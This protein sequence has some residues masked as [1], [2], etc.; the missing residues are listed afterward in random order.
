M[1]T[2]KIKLAYIVSS[3]VK[4]GPV[5]VILDI[6]TNI[7][8]NKFEVFIITLA[9]EKKNSLEFEFQK[10]P[11]HIIKFDSANKFNF[12]YH[13]LKLSRFIKKNNIEIIHS[14]CFRSLIYCHL[15]KKEAK[16]IHTIHNN[17]TLQAVSLYGKILGCTIS[18]ITKILIKSNNCSIACSKSV[19][20]DL[21]EKDNIAVS[22]IANGVSIPLHQKFRK[23]DEI[24][25]TL[26]LEDGVVYFLSIGRFSPEKNFQFLVKS[27]IDADLENSKLIILG[28]GK[29]YEKIKII[30]NQNIILPGFKSNV[31]EYIKACN[32]YISASLTEGM[33]LS[34]L[35]AMALGLPLILSDIP[36]HKEIFQQ[37]KKIGILFQNSNKTNLIASLREIY[38]KQNYN[39]LSDNA[40]KIFESYYTSKRMTTEYTELYR[41]LIK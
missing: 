22:Y 28:D 21:K 4:E 18:L 31:Y 25:K 40:K 17:P 29:D 27:F 32:Y 2:K 1:D 37:N 3:L 12:L 30:A 16:H 14:H 33:P 36:P 11:L 35:E 34:V 41:T 6:I 15:S 38:L 24:R 23:K 13:Y 8:F 9:K 10:F 26:N 20:T 19:A 39:I 5:Q 7:D